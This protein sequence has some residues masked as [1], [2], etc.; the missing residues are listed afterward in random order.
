MAAA[1]FYGL[2][3]AFKL[4]ILMRLA[5]RQYSRHCYY[6]KSPFSG[7]EEEGCVFFIDFSFL[8][9]NETVLLSIL[10]WEV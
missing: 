1:L 9:A 8:V 2:L 7:F 5:I 6:L 4:K 3:H 10:G